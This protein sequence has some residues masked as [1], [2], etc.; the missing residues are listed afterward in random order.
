MLGP[1][2]QDCPHCAFADARLRA[3]SLL[4]VRLPIP[5]PVHG[6]I[7]K[8]TGTKCDLRADGRFNPTI[9]FLAQADIKVKYAHWASHIAI[10]YPVRGCNKNRAWVGA[11]VSARTLMQQAYTVAPPAALTLSKCFTVFYEGALSKN[12]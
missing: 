12:G 2:H 11:N 8:R 7:L 3:H 10:G 1:R 9:D 5:P 4:S 6:T